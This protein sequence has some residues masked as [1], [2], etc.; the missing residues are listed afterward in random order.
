MSNNDSPSAQFEEVFKLIRES[1]EQIIHEINVHLIDLYWNV[2]KYLS[3][4][5]KEESWGKSVVSSLSRFLT[6]QEPSLKGFSAQN[7]WRMKQFYEFYIKH[8]ILSP[9]VREINWTNNL[10]ILSKTKSP[11][12]TEF[13]L[14]L[15]IQE[16]YT[17]RE[18]E[19][20]I[21]SSIYERW[22]LSGNTIPNIVQPID[23]KVI[24]L[25][26]QYV[27]DFLNLQT[28]YSEADFQR[29]I[30]HDLKSFLLEVGKDLSFVGENYRIQV[31]SHDYFIDLLFF[32][33]GLSCLVAL[34]LKIDDF[35]PEYAGKMAFYLEA[36]DRRLRKSG[37]NPPVGII[38]C[39]G[40]DDDVV[41][42]TMS[43]N[44]SRT[45]IAEY[46]MKLI[47]KEKLKQ[48][49][50]DLCKRYEARSNQDHG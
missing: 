17:K 16:K 11:K 42:Y 30:L 21:E 29:A 48:R 2:G 22:E 14:N 15:T 50:R 34:E 33:R 3:M 1:K 32:H 5:V 18:L 38:L 12:E 46:R 49:L 27:L 23:T 4:K 41:E 43:K 20:Q 26:D 47:P 31:G 45:L 8:E 7:L 39:K 9:L 24:M 25:K 10:L 36:I 37:E 44:I 13:Y 40:K 19:R 28:T 35:K 6:S